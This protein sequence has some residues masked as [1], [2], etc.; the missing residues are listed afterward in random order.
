MSF[1]EL[2]LDYFG[3]AGASS[4]LVDGA[5]RNLF[6]GV[7][8]LAPLLEALLDVLVLALSLRTPRILW[9]RILA[10]E[11]RNFGQAVPSVQARQTRT[12][13][14][15]FCRQTRGYTLTHG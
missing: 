1:V 14:T 10:F 13:L 6:G 4:F 8:A 3:F 7:F 5:S 2:R 15:T 9:H 12:R 11:S